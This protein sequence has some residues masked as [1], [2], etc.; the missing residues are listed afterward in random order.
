MAAPDTEMEMERT[1]S[2]TSMQAFVMVHGLFM[3]L[4][5]S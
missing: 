2:M 4:D 5:G 3:R 1:A